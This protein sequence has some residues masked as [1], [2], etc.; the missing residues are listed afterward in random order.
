MFRRHNSRCLEVHAS[1]TRKGFILLQLTPN[2]LLLLQ[3][4]ITVPL[5]SEMHLL[6]KLTVLYYSIIRTGST[7][8][9]SLLSIK[10]EN[11]TAV[12]KLLYVATGCLGYAKGK[13]DALK[14]EHQASDL[15]F[16]LDAVCK[17]CH[18]LNLTWFLR[19][20]TKPQLVERFLGLD[21]MYAH[22]NAQRMFESKY[23]ARELLW[24]GFIVCYVSYFSKMFCNCCFCTGNIG[25]CTSLNKLP[26]DQKKNE[27]VQSFL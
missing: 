16:K 17:V 4:G 5:E 23:M 19:N 21:Q 1:K 26:Q 27:A 25:L 12:K 8:G 10:Y 3:P 22:E 11:L 15:L 13:L 2:F 20:G 6:I 9:Q 14:Q 7:F 18:L 24:N